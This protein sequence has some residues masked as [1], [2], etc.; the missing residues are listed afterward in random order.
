MSGSG[1]ALPEQRHQPVSVLPVSMMSS[2]AGCAARQLGLR[3]VQQPTL[4]LDTV[5]S[6]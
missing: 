4:P 5:L 3:I 2:T 6:P 1:P